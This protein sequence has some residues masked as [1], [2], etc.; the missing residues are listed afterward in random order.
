VKRIVTTVA[1]PID[2]LL[3]GA[4]PR[5]E[6]VDAFATPVLPGD[7]ATP[8]GWSLLSL[9]TVPRWVA[10]AMWLR[11]AI[12]RPFGLLV[13]TAGMDLGPMAF[14]KLARTDTEILYGLNDKHLDFRVVLRVADGT[15]TFATM[16]QVNNALGRV[17]WS[18]VRRIH[19]FVVRS[20]LRSAPLP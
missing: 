16:V 9:E 5:A 10:G 7:P 11:H 1:A 12:V 4:L 19:P 20:L 14:P 18:V 13:P 8:E 17:Y 6:H 2:G 15:A 3:P